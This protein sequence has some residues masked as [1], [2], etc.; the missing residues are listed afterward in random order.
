MATIGGQILCQAPDR[1]SSIREGV[2]RIEDD[3]IVEV[4][5]EAISGSVDWGDAETFITPG[6]IDTHLHLPQFDSIGAFGMPLLD[7][8]SEVI[9]PAEENWNDMDYARSMIARVIDQCLSVGTTGICAYATSSYDATITAL[10][11]FQR[12]G[13]RGVIGQAMMDRAAPMSLTVPTEQLIEQVEA[14]LQQFPPTGRMATAVTPRFALSCTESALLAAA[15]LA[16]RFDAMIQTHLAETRREC[17]VVSKH[18]DGMPYVDVYDKMGLVTERSVFGHGIYLDDL[19]VARL[20]QAGSVIAHCPTANSFL[21]S[22][23]MNRNDHLAHG[24]RLSLGSDVGAGFERSMVRVGRAMIEA[25]IAKQFQSDAFRRTGMIDYAKVPTA[26]QAWYQIT[27]GN[28]EAV[29]WKDGGRIEV[30]QPADLVIVQPDVPWRLARCPL[31]T[32]MYS[33]DDRWVRHTIVNGRHYTIGP[34]GAGVRTEKGESLG[35]V[36]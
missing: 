26:P 23:T 35:A 10:D 3:R 12:V 24:V 22:G 2:V 19:S 36:R 11:M 30:G 21:G 5:F 28:A 29:R 14:A 31:S 4:S 1:S 9:F 16:R 25:A 27:A 32:L 33:W 18:F 13:L 8:L 6:F 17:E 7:W 20:V 15:D 34:N